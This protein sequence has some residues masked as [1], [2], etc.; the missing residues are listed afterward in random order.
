MRIALGADHAGFALKA[1]VRRL[2]GERRQ[3]CEDLGPDTGDP[4]DYPDYAARVARGVAA[5]A[6]DRGIL[7]CGSGVGMAIAAN[8]V[9]GVRAAA[10]TTPDAAR[11]ARRHNDANVLALG[12][13]TLPLDVALRIVDAFLTT[14]FDGGRH[15]RRVD[16]IAALEAE[17]IEAGSLA[18]AGA[19]EGAEGTA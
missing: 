8:K 9:R 19:L 16:K 1:H 7:I 12:A 14:P 11:L 2:L 5:G 6:F 4:V 18:P 17:D 10:V 15:Q 13:R 3:A